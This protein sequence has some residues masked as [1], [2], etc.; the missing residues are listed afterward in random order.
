MKGTP[1]GASGVRIRASNRRYERTLVRAFYDVTGTT[2]G[3]HDV[4]LAPT[5]RIKEE[6]AG[7]ERLREA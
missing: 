7:R 3:A 6:N 4:D 5:V 1:S 2:P